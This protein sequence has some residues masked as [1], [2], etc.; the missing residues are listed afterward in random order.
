MVT[1]ISITSGFI[2]PIT[3]TFEFISGVDIFVDK[4]VR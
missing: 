2:F 4:T 3:E 1:Q